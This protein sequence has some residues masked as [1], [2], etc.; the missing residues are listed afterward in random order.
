MFFLM[1]YGISYT[2]P[3]EGTPSFFK[4]GV[5]ASVIVPSPF[6]MSATTSGVVNGSNPLLAHS[7]DAKKLF[8]SIHNIFLLT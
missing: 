3:L 5:T 8:K 6:Y 7:T 4:Y 1:L 2:R